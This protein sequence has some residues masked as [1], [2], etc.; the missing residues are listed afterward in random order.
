[1]GDRDI[2]V[3]AGSLDE[4][5]GALSETLG[6]DEWARAQRMRAGPLRQRFVARRALRRAVL[7]VCT[8]WDPAELHFGD[9]SGGKPALV[10]PDVEFSCSSSGGLALVAVARGRRVGVDVERIRRVTD[11]LGIASSLLPP[12]DYHALREMPDDERDAAFLRVWTGKEA[13][14]KACGTGLSMSLDHLPMTGWCV[15][16]IPSPS[17]FVAAACAE[18]TDWRVCSHVWRWPS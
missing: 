10:G 17:G 5:L 18:G 7:A 8:G 11:P 4:P 3:W 16:E 13:R 12:S 15:S 9:G 1:M 6:V 14:V 2:H